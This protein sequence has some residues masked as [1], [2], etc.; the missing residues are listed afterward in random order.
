MYIV[1]NRYKIL[2]IT[3]F[4]E[5]LRKKE[6]II[7]IIYV[8]S[9][10]IVTCIILLLSSEDMARHLGRELIYLDE[11]IVV[12]ISWIGGFIFGIL[13]GF[14][15]FLGSEE[16][17]Y[18]Y[19]RTPRGLTSLITSYVIE[20]VYIIIFLD[21]LITLFF[22]FLFKLQLIVILIFFLMYFIQC[23]ILL[24]QAV[25]IQCYNPLFDERSKD[26]FFNI[27][28]ITTLQLLSLIISLFIT[29]PYFPYS[30][31]LSLGLIIILISNS[32][33][34]FGISSLVLLLGF[35]KLKKN[36]F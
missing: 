29:I 5:F 35:Q 3:Q 2:V 14:N 28:L 36:E 8:F 21:L 33:I 9:L 7:K 15:F 34:S 31:D 32:I 12:L 4:K 6:N 13:I 23:V 20:M 11:L 25:G 16:M 24:F 19:K 26:I 18:L 10:T 30:T 27:Y 1:I 17:I 22:M